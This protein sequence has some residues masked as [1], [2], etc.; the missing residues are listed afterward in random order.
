MPTGLKLQTTFTRHQQLVRSVAW[1]PDGTMLASGADDS[2]VFIWGT[3]GV[4]H[5]NVAHPAAVQSL[6]WSPDGKRLVTSSGTQLAFFDTRT[7]NRL[8]RSIHAHAQMITGVAW[9]TQGL[10]QVVSVS[11]DKHAIVWNTTNYQLQ[12][13]YQLHGTAIEAVSWSADG[14]TVATASKGGY[15][16]IWSG[17]NG[18]D[19]HAHYQ[20]MSLPIRA[21]AFSPTGMQLAAG[22]DDGTVHL[23]K[24]GLACQKPQG[25]GNNS[26][27]TDIPQLLRASTSAVRTLAWSHDGRYIAVGAN[28]GTLSVW[29]PESPPQPLLKMQQKET[30]HSVAWSPDNKYLAVASENT[31]TTWMII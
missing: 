7:G 12:I 5:S 26:I 30:V 25:Q 15:I 28:D 17:S 3:D 16:R 19:V 23:W 31:V 1:S 4:V 9:A 10:K 27:C 21:L 11:L 13:V 20:D 8:A 6:A 24:N 29:D 18:V 14:Q 2:Q 22:V